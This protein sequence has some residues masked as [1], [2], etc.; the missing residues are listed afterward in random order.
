[1]L[2]KKECNW[3]ETGSEPDEVQIEVEAGWN[4]ISTGLGPCG[5]LLDLV[6]TKIGLKQVESDQIRT[7]VEPKS[8]WRNTWEPDRNQIGSDSE[9][10]QN[11]DMV[12]D[13]RLECGRNWIKSELG[14]D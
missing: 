3:T 9:Y 4:W 2:R 8:V 11:R 5:K 12:R 13:L 14:P 10:G 1:M 6:K 7:N